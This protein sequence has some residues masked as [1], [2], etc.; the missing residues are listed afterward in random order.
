LLDNLKKALGDDEN[1]T[2]EAAITHCK[3]VWHAH[4]GATAV[5]KGALLPA[6][7]KAYTARQADEVAWMIPPVPVVGGVFPITGQLTA[8]PPGA[9][10]QSRPSITTF[11]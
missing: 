1:V 7:I 5:T 8:A 4:A 10:N 6:I 3:S 9:S 2:H 11:S